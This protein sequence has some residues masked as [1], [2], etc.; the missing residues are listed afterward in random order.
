[1]RF[2]DAVGDFTI[3]RFETG[4]HVTFGVWIRG[5]KGIQFTHYDLQVVRLWCA[6]ITP[7]QTQARI[8]RD[9]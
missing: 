6:G 3:A 5:T 7:E 4:S 1:M 2:I 9:A 8:Y